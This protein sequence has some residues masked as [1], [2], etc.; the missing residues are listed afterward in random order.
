MDDSVFFFNDEIIGESAR[1]VTSGAYPR[2][3]INQ[4]FQLQFR[5]EPFEIFKEQP[6]AHRTDHLI[7]TRLKVA[8]AAFPKS[9]IGHDVP[10]I[11]KIHIRPTVTRPGQSQYGIRARFHRFVQHSRQMNPQKGKLGIDDRI[12]KTPHQIAAMGNQLVVL[13]A[14]WDNA[15]GMSGSGMFGDAVGPKPSA[16]DDLI[17]YKCSSICYNLKSV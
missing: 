16:V 12:D 4:V 10:H 17:G 11:L 8:A 7:E 5:N 9:R 6:L 3:F 15:M 14:K 13:A 1:F 2:S